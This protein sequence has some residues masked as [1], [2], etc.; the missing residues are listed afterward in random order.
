MSEYQRKIVEALKNGA[1]LQCTEGVG[2]KTWLVYPNGK[3][4]N[5]RRDSAIK[6]CADFFDNL[7]FGESDGIRWI[8]RDIAK[9]RNNFVKDFYN[10][11]NL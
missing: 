4:E 5:I 11:N 1:K 2:Y 10:T 9:C 3:T 6:V 7:C 8:V